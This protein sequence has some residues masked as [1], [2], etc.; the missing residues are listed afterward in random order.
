ML[1]GPC[2]EFNKKS[3]CM[4]NGKCHFG[5]PKA[6]QDQTTLSE[7]GYLLYYQPNDGRSY[8]VNGFSYDNR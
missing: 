7:D 5:F 3:P 6:F 2:G 1:H 8:V 4:H